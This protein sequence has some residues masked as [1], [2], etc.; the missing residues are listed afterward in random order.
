MSLVCSLQNILPKKHTTKPQKHPQKHFRWHKKGMW[1]L[2]PMQKLHLLAVP[3]LQDHQVH[4]MMC[5]KK[6]HHLW[7]GVRVILD[8]KPVHVTKKSWSSCWVSPKPI[9]ATP[10]GCRMDMFSGSNEQGMRFRTLRA[11][12]FVERCSCG[13]SGWSN[14]WHLSELNLWILDDDYPLNIDTSMI[15]WCLFWCH[16]IGTQLQS[17]PQNCAVYP[18]GFPSNPFWGKAKINGQPISPAHR[19]DPV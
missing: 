18:V 15:H 12:K 16:I 14:P 5:T 7:F 4:H 9:H 13:G 17:L 1:N 8:R 2:F 3:L 6:Y 19:G 10:R 11:L